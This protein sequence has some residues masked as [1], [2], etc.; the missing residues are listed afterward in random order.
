MPHWY[1]VETFLCEEVADDLCLVVVQ[2]QRK[3]GPSGDI[4]LSE[5][6][7]LID[8]GV[9]SQAA[10]PRG[11]SATASIIARFER[12]DPPR[13]LVRMITV[14][15][16]ISVL[17][18]SIDFINVV[19]ILCAIGNPRSHAMGIL[20]SNLSLNLLNAIASAYK[21][22]A[23][24][25]P[26]G[27]R[28]HQL[29]TFIAQ[30][31]E[32]L[33]FAVRHL[34]L[35]ILLRFLPGMGI[36]ICPFGVIGVLC[37]YWGW[38]WIGWL[39][40]WLALALM[41]MTLMCGLFAGI[42]THCLIPKELLSDVLLSDYGRLGLFHVLIAELVYTTSTWITFFTI[43]MFNK[44][45]PTW[46]WRLYFLCLATATLMLYPS[47]IATLEGKVDAR[48]HRHSTK[49]A[50]LCTMG[51]RVWGMR[52][53]VAMVRTAKGGDGDISDSDDGID[54]R[55]TLSACVCVFAVDGGDGARCGNDLDDAGE[56]TAGRQET[57]PSHTRHDTQY[58]CGPSHRSSRPQLH[59]SV[60]VCLSVCMR[61]CPRHV[62]VPQQLEGPAT[63]TGLQEMATVNNHAVAASVSVLRCHISKATHS[64]LS[65]ALL[66][67]SGRMAGVCACMYVLI[68]P[69]VADCAQLPWMPCCAVCLLDG[70]DL[71]T[72]PADWFVVS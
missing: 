7:R 68:R 23:F 30:I 32:D 37:A 59:P 1:A 25:P 48:A 11:P 54:G 40:W 47:L 22:M 29:A 35:N 38:S 41:L 42:V 24:E 18:D 14:L 39:F 55:R 57:R 58:M 28:M 53:T 43:A 3:K 8:S 61:V 69:Q 51:L 31:P 71:L 50:R 45:V 2:V 66:M 17:N 10:T 9:D 49:A 60:S 26:S 72:G 15:S 34:T 6:S 33:E 64:I 62:G 5:S 67:A 70:L 27:E 44:R 19:I 36:F 65:V 63:A 52:P 56:G 16:G 46:L 13:W 21:G 20:I 4:E 12:P